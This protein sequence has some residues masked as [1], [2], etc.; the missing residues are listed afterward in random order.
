MNTVYAPAKLNL[1]FEIVGKRPDGY[2]D[3]RSVMQTIDLWDVL[4]FRDA[5][6]FS[7]TGAQVCDREDSPI[8]RAVRELEN[9]VG[10]MIPMNIHLTKSI[11]IGSGLGGGS[12]DAAATLTG[13][14]EALM[15]GLDIGQLKEIALKVGADVAFFLLGGK[16]LVEGR[17]EKLTKLPADPPNF[18]YVVFRPHKRLSSREAYE[19][20]DR[21]G[22]TF[23]EMC[24]EKA[25]QLEKVFEVFPNAVISGK[26]PSTWI[27]IN[28]EYD[29]YLAAHLNLFLPGWDGDIFVC[30]PIEPVD[31]EVS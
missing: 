20:Y 8:T 18:Y 13:L 23:A 16:C 10:F 28:H 30:R 14:N 12:S 7:L 11:P 9:Y 4:E 31:K 15:L 21:L 6:F 27:K 19:D 1:S 22:K 5:D 24:R 29:A 2:H 26:G 17:G 3:I 25:P